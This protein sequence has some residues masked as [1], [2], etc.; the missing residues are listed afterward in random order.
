ME[1]IVENLDFDI[2]IVVVI[3]F[4]CIAIVQKE[5]GKRLEGTKYESI[6]KNAMKILTLG[7]VNKVNK[8]VAKDDNDKK[9]NIDK[10]WE[11]L[12][13]PEQAKPEEKKEEK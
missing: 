12:N 7:L 5:I 13:K 4:S 8:K 10:V 11:E 6:F 3:I 2:L 9:E 1:T